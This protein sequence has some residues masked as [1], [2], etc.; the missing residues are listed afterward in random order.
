[1]SDLNNLANTVFKGDSTKV[2]D[3]TQKLI[4]DGVDPLAIIN[5]GLIAGMDIVAPKFKAGE[6]FVPEVMMCAKALHH[7]L[8]L[9]KPLIAEADIPSAGTIVVGTVAGDLHDI[10]KNLVI[11]IME[12]GGF[13]VID[14]GVNVSPADFVEAI[15]KHHPQ[16]VGMSALLT[17]T[18]MAMKQTIDAIRDAGLRDKV[19]IIVGGAPISQ[20]FADEIGADGYGA[21]AMSARD[22]CMQFIA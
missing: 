21:D 17:T 18:M 6:M 7:G 15:K 19:K 16:V 8:N 22:L 11:M 13:K 12:S 14:L 5:E 2:K 20:D 1:M 9:V 4:Q 10:G 3:L